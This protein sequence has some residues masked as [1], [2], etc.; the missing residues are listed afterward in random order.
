MAASSTTGKGPGSCNKPTTKELAAIVNGPL[1]IMTGI[2]TSDGIP[3]SPPGTQ[4]IVRFEQPLTNDADSY[5]VLLTPL[6]GTGAYVA[7]RYESGGKFSGFMVATEDECDVF[8]L[9]APVGLKPKI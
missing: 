7:Q 2:V 4:S 9:V 3:S 1:T 5:V 6:N 8:Y